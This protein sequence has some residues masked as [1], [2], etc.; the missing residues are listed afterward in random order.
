MNT[1]LMMLQGYMDENDTTVMLNYIFTAIFIAE[2][3]LKLVALSPI[4]YMRDSMN[5]FD[6]IIVIFSII[7]LS[8]SSGFDLKAF[9]SLRILRTLR[10]LRVTKLLR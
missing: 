8:I 6:G 5:M 1:I 4:G 10:V 7:D 2:F 9:R 3:A